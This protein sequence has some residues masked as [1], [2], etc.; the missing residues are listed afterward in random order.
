MEPS[1]IIPAF[2][3]GILTFLAP[4]TL[5]LVPGYLGFISGVAAGQSDKFSH[6]WSDICF[7]LDSMCRPYLRINFDACRGIGNGRPRGVS[8]FGFLSRTCSAVPHNRRR[9]RFCVKLYLKVEQ[10]SQC[11]FDYWG[12]ISCLS[13]Y[14]SL[15]EQARRVDRIL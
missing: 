6:F 4:C 14:P 13:W 9:Y 8:S 2:I 10:V 5:P 7:W 3:A 11:Y 15:H 1:L 12:I